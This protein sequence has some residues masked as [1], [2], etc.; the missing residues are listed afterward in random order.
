MA[1]MIDGLTVEP[2]N[3][4][5]SFLVYSDPSRKHLV[6]CGDMGGNGS[7]SCQH[8][9]FRLMSKLNNGE[10]ISTATRCKHILA[11][12][13]ILADILIKNL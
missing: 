11:A 4:L 6:N 1:D 12:R 7:C 3:A 2:Y 5:P 13:N 8:F 9:Q 10:P